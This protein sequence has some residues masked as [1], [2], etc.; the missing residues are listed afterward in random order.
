MLFSSLRTK[1][2]LLICF[3]TLTSLLIASGIFYHFVYKISV[4]QAHEHI[5]NETKLISMQ[6]KNLY[7]QFANNLLLVSNTPPIKGIIRSKN[8]YDVDPQEDSTLNQWHHRLE[9]IFI[10]V[11]N[12]NN[13]SYTQMRLIGL[14]DNG[15]ELVRVNR[16]QQGLL[17]V[18]PQNK[19][20]QKGDELYFKEATNLKNGQ[21]YYSNITYNREYGKI[22]AD[23]T[24]TI[25]IITPIYDNNKLFGLLVINANYQIL[26]KTA[27]E[28]I[29]PSQN[30]YIINDDG[31]YFKY[32]NKKNEYVYFSHEDKTNKI[33]THVEYSLKLDTKYNNYH[34]DEFYT[35]YIKEQIS[36][37]SFGGQNYIII[38]LQIRN[39]ELFAYTYFLK[40]SLLVIMVFFILLMVIISYLFTL[41]II[42]PLTL[43]I[44]TIKDY[45]PYQ[46][47][48]LDLPTNSKDEI[49]DLAK[50]FDNMITE[51]QSTIQLD[52]LTGLYRRNALYAQILSVTQTLH[53]KK[54][55]LLIGVI[56]IDDFKI[57]NDTYGH[58]KGDDV[59]KAIATELKF[60]FRETDRISRPGGDEFII[61]CIIDHSEHSW[62]YSKV[63]QAIIKANHMIALDFEYSGSCGI[64]IFTSNEINDVDDINKQITFADQLMYQNKNKTKAT[65][66]Q[67]VISD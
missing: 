52:D 21:V 25:R 46:S 18:V 22:S 59:L 11:M 12:N 17:K 58:T 64:S 61:F 23:Q 67:K 45:H 60:A 10:S 43:M 36:N 47:E 32:D 35:Y 48:K 31:G 54:Q 5:A 1:I 39:D 62:F 28:N 50:A 20:Q 44:N 51:L 2:I 8:N 29:S 24:P 27:I 42:R 15:R 9:T 41:K 37:H 33:P 66:Q 49:G 13:N 55:L 7:S 6:I 57:I 65:K 40:N 3:L 4:K 53:R 14:E 16:D 30:L 63:Q 26:I 34:D 56:D 19:M 38:A